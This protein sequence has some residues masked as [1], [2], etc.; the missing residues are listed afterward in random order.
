MILRMGV[1]RNV[2][3]IGG[4]VAKASVSLRFMLGW[5]VNE[6]TKYAS[7]RGWECRKI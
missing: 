2:V 5:G 4:I 1:K 7:E 3:I 6:V